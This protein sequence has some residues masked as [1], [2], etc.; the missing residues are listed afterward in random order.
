MGGYGQLQISPLR[1]L[2]LGGIGRCALSGEMLEMKIKAGENGG[3]AS[4][5]S[6]SFDCAS[7]EETARGFAQ[8]DAFFIYQFLYLSE[9]ATV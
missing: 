8:D 9:D 5:N 4:V 2:P 7:R 6:R 1:T 3:T